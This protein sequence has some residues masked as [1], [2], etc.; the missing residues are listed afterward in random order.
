MLLQATIEDT[1]KHLALEQ[2]ENGVPNGIDAI[3]RDTRMLFRRRGHDPQY[4]MVSIDAS[5]AFNNFSRKAV[6][7][8]LPKRAPSLS[9]YLDMSYCRTPPPFI[10]P[11][12]PP[13]V[14]SSHEGTQQGDPS[15]ILLFSLALQPLASRISESCDLLMNRWYAD[16]RTIVGRVEEVLKAPAL[17]K[18]KD[19][20]HQFFLNPKRHVSFGLPS[21]MT[22]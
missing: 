19:P 4:N 14:L 12:S 18:A 15:S 10:V 16:D 21:T 17:I 2:I 9:R 5:N 20:K 3:V 1:R 8:T 13:T 7:R 22:F 6:L 11:S